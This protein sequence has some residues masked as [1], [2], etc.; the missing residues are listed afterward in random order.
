MQKG[1]T[2]LGPFSERLGVDLMSL[3]GKK[4]DEFSDAGYL[5][6]S[7]DSVTLTRDGI[8]FGNNLLSELF[9]LG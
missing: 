5:T 2:R 3:F 7:G 8:F 9:K 4:L 1:G 6:V